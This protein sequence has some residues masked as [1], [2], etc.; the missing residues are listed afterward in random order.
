MAEPT[1]REQRSYRLLLLAITLAY[2]VVFTKL[3]FDQHAGMR[4]HQADLG[5]IDQAIW[6]SSHGR[7]LEFTKGEFQSIRLTDHVEPI[8]VLISPIFWLWNDV[9][10]LLVLQVLA[11]AIGAWLLYALAQRKTTPLIAIALAIAYFLAPQT[12][13]AL[14][15]EF[16]AI[17]LAAPFIFWAFWSLETEHWGQFVVAAL[18]LAS[19]KEEAALLAAGLGLWAI[20]VGW[21]KR[22][23]NKR[24]LEQQETDR[25]TP[26]P[27]ASRFTFHASRLSLIT[28]V[29]VLLISL[30]GFA[31]ATFVII[32]RHA[33]TVYGVEASIYFH[34]YG[35]LGDNLADIARSLLTR[36]DLVWR[37][38]TEPARLRYLLGLFAGFGFVCLFGIDIILLCLPLLLANALSAFPAQYYGEFHYSAPL[39]P[40]FAVAAAYGAS[41]LLQRPFAQN[42]GRRQWSRLLA[43]W[44]LAWAV[45]L[46]LL[47]GRGPLG[48]RYDPIPITA[49]HRL[50][51]RFLARIPAEAAA[52]ATASVHPHISHR[53]R[54]YQFPNGLT[55]PDG[56]EWALI[57][58][59]TDTDMAP[60]AVRATVEQMLTGTWGIIDAADGFLLLQKHTPNKTIPPAF[61][62]FVRGSGDVATALGPLGFVDLRVDDWPRW[63]QIR[64]TTRWQ[65]GQN[66]VPGTVRPWLEVRSPDGRPVFT[67]D[68]LAPPALVWY[69][70]TQW[71]PG[72]AITIT[73]TPL[74]LPRAWGAVLGVAHGPNPF[75][76]GN[77]LPADWIAS[78][79]LPRTPDDTLFL[80]AAF[81]RDERGRLKALPLTRQDPPA[82]FDQKL[83]AKEGMFMTPTGQQIHVEA[84][85]P[86]QRLEPGRT[87]DI[88]LRWSAGIPAGYTPSVQLRQ[89]ETKI[90]QADGPPWRFIPTATDDWRQLTLPPGVAPGVVLG[91]ALGLYNQTD[92]SRLA[93]QDATG[94]PLGAEL[95]LGNIVVGRPSIPDQACALDPNACAS[96]P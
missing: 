58:V 35:A 15:T 64:L 5:Q 39:T 69:P 18:L 85:L 95:P 26:P 96:Q 94:Q 65:A 37:I 74:S 20:W 67:L 30:I 60:G 12:Q 52:T 50:L 82:D 40:Y 22:R 43:L 75:E 13:S 87:L 51:S 70:P 61:Y 88:W 84:W 32:P 89:G 72:E 33:S 2:I 25:Q 86:A 59:T 23:E 14:L 29:T 49:H 91:L 45:G 71:Q 16:H 41:R 4:T 92:G 79:D 19:V 3:A 46:Y 53:K 47:A 10:A 66:L 21:G 7:F 6:N 68:K 48:G 38:L 28:G 90:T 57:D 63:R 1:A 80:A 62:D 73:T 42:T 34:R 55:E 36:P 8:F 93:I 76:P 17:P 31:L 44:V 9:R 83:L 54:A 78:P 56:A 27:H 24:A 11:V 77:R 81:R